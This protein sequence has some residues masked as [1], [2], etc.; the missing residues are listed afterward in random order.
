MNGLRNRV[1]LVLSIASIGFG[2][3]FLSSCINDLLTVK[4]DLNYSDITLIIDSTSQTGERS[5]DS[6]KV[7]SNLDSVLAANN[8]KK[9]QIESVKLKSVRLEIIDPAGSNFLALKS[10]EAWMATEELSFVP[11]AFK[12]SIPQTGS[13]VLEMDVNSQQELVNYVKAPNYLIHVKGNVKKPISERL[14]VRVMIVFE[15][16]VSA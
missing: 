12:D 10:V 3:S 1:I 13:N 15:V 6:V 2:V 9:E 8:T 5:L 7:A 16:T 4:F 11:I 14:T